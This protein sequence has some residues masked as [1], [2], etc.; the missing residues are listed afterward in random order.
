MGRTRQPVFTCGVEN[1]NI[2]NEELCKVWFVLQH[3]VMNH[4][5]LTPN[6]AGQYLDNKPAASTSPVKYQRVVTVS[7]QN[8]NNGERI[9]QEGDSC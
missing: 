4:S 6:T 5:S 3:L 1:V 2:L 8:N 9:P 7:G